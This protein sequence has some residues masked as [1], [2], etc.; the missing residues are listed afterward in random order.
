M[1]VN[2]ISQLLKKENGKVWVSSLVV[3]N[4]LEKMHSNILRDI[5]RLIQKNPDLLAKRF[6]ESY[7]LDA[8]GKKRVCI[9][10][11]KFG[12]QHL[13]SVFTSEKALEYKELFFDA[14]DEMERALRSQSIERQDI[15]EWVL[16]RLASKEARKEFTSVIKEK[17]EDPNYGLITNDIYKTAW[18]M[19]AHEIRKSFNLP[20][21]TNLRRR[22]NADCNKFL[23][24]IE[25][26]LKSRLEFIKDKVNMSIVRKVVQELV[27]SF[28]VFVKEHGGLVEIGF[29]S[30]EEAFQQEKLLKSIEREKKALEKNKIL[31]H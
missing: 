1:S 21:N 30:D 29:I 23:T 8:Q 15:K 16:A 20:S 9:L 26:Q 7:Y 18:A 17:V 22:F 13:V 19:T 11:D 27:S 25:E 6:V 14:F 28:V 3:A 5:R 2:D 10:M 12:F 31:A 4:K 24:H